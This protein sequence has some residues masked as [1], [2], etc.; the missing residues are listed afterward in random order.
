MRILTLHFR[1]LNSLR[2]DWR[3]DFTAPE[4]LSNGIFAITGPTGAGKTTLLDGICLALFGATPRLGKITKS[5]NEIMS[6]S[7]GECFAEVEFLAGGVRYRC[8][9]SQHRARRKPGGDLQQHKHE[10]VDA[11]TGKVLET[12][13]KEV[14]NL[15]EQITGLEFAQFT[16][17]MLLAQGDF[18][19]FLNAEASER[20]P[21]LEQITGTEIYSE[22]SIQVHERWTDEKK[23]TEAFVASLGSVELFSDEVEEAMQARK[24]GLHEHVQLLQK[25]L[26]SVERQ[27]AY[28]AEIDARQGE[29]EELSGKLALHHEE[30]E[31]AAEDL[32][33][34]RLAQ[35]AAA[36]HGPY[37]AYL[38]ARQA[39]EEDAKRLD[40]LLEQETKNRQA[41]K[42]LQQQVTQIR[43]TVNEFEQHLAKEQELLKQVR[44]LDITVG[45]AEK[46]L[47]RQQSE[48]QELQKEHAAQEKKQQ[49]Q[50]RRRQGI[51][52]KKT[53]A[54]SYLKKHGEDE[55]LVEQMQDIA[56]R[57]QR[58][59]T[60]E[61]Q[62][63]ETLES[64]EKYAGERKQAA[65]R[66]E[67][68][69]KQYTQTREEYTSLEKQ[70]A[71]MVAEQ[72]KRLAGSNIQALREDL[73][74]IRTTLQKIGEI[75]TWYGQQNEVLQEQEQNRSAQ[76]LT[77]EKL[78]GCRDKLASSRKE[79]ASREKLREQLQLNQQLR[80]TIVDFTEARSRLI[81][82]EPCPLCGSVNHPWQEQKPVVTDQ[83]T[84][85]SQVEKELK[86]LGEEIALIREQRAGLEQAEKSNLQRSQTLSKALQRLQEQI[87]G[88]IS[89]CG[90]E[91]IPETSEELIS[92]EKELGVL[93]QQ[94]QQTITA[95]D[96][97]AE[98]LQKSQVALSRLLDSAH[99]HETAFKEAQ[100]AV[101]RVND[102]LQAAEQRRQETEKGV[103]VLQ[104]ELILQL[105]PFGIDH[106][107]DGNVDPVLQQL[108]ARRKMWLEAA[109][110]HTAAERDLAAITATLEGLQAAL[111]EQKL[112]LEK[113]EAGVAEAGA[114]VK[115]LQQERL[116]L[117]GT[118]VP[119]T[120]EQQLQSRKESLQQQYTRLQEQLQ[121]SEKQGVQLA[122][123][124]L[125]TRDSLK[126]NT[127]LE[128][129]LWDQF[130]CLLQKKGFAAVEEF[131]DALLN[132]QEL[133]SLALLKQNLLKNHSRLTV[134][135]KEK[136]LALEH[137]QQ[138]DPPEKSAEELGERQKQLSRQVEE[139]LQ[140]V[141]ALSE[142]LQRNELAK[143]K[144]KAQLEQ[145]KLQQQVED[146]WGRLHQL[147]GSADGKKFRVFAQ[148]MTLDLVIQHANRH[149]RRM[150]DR[151]LLLRS[152]EQLLDL[153]VVD[154][155]QAGEIRSTKNLSG[156]ESFIVSLAL[157]LGLSSM[158]GRSIRID[159]LFLDEGFGTLD[160]E[161]LEVALQA[162]SELQRSG[163]LIGVISHV[164]M[165]QERIGV[166][167]QVVPGSDGTSLLEGPGC[168]R[169]Q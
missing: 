37:Q 4:F 142:Q 156:G 78:A 151:Y 165:M 160:E 13:V 94:T 167:I 40:S 100:H 168:S 99:R 57:L 114:Q 60:L 74:R 24:K 87:T 104:D 115:A 143:E 101:E 81:S 68:A 135:F 161:A 50:I 155:Y 10:L 53:Q 106:V 124:V 66:L 45:A 71:G 97:D 3:I 131:L 126:R 51:L 121:Q 30:C 20:A 17:S 146:R 129:K 139:I 119:D 52:E 102:R 41:G 132:D 70:H 77:A 18:A 16:R 75:K 19:A 58:L 133:N 130:T 56:G 28:L 73:D 145:L 149:L 79:Q 36:V 93:L 25:E 65:V 33:R 154:S 107:P 136:F 69:G 42:Q 153:Q 2:G 140:Q 12:K 39:G 27:I 95:I 89:E 113:K 29:L 44:A 147:I 116:A 49:E 117:Y 92:V 23:Q 62:K 163:K 105:R 137:L 166:Q 80:K 1:N 128:Q 21:I 109:D 111:A 54:E 31:Q 134:L 152:P 103:Q 82:G 138:A 86:N 61:K 32:F 125:A 112:R 141:G 59:I 88:G 110:N 90:L 38:S 64:L 91:K 8:H 84:E 127:E 83:S 76:Q 118:K 159:S 123:K 48:Y 15:V 26:G 46:H 67:T 169:I 108:Q 43:E 98:K 144:Q 14:A 164:P 63:Q 162:L 122:E 148:G 11:A 7:T 35:Q 85:L 150:N 5:A 34:Y 157:S 55:Q 22:I 158:A 6:R 47:S 9:W 96:K 72:Q 120:E